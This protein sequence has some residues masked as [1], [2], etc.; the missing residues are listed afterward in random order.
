MNPSP[1]RQAW[2]DAAR[3]KA[4]FAGE[5]PTLETPDTL[6]TLDDTAKGRIAAVYQE[7]ADKWEGLIE[8][9]MQ[10]MGLSRE[11]RAAAV[12]AL[13]LRQQEAARGA[14]GRLSKR[15][16]K[17]S[18]PSVATGGSWRG[19]RKPRYRQRLRIFP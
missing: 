9:A 2:R 19:D 5:R 6:A 7:E 18:K 17:S 3:G 13:R 16:T 4:Y 1:A 15:N 8:A 12:L 14:Q 10:N 11:R